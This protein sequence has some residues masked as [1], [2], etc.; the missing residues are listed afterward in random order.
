MTAR[1]TAGAGGAGRGSRRRRCW[2]V[3]LLLACWPAGASEPGVLADAGSPVVVKFAAAAD[4]A[5]QLEGRFTVA[6]SP[7]AAWGVLTDYDHLSDFVSSM[8]S[9]RVKVRDDGFV[10]VEQESAGKLLFFQ[11]TFHVL[12]KVREEPRK[13]IAF[14][15]VSG[16]SFKQYLGAWTL[17]ETNGGLEVIYRLTARGG[18]AAPA[19]MMRGASRKMV[20]DLLEQVRHRISIGAGR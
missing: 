4:G 12:L 9:S 20:G 15:D 2:P 5:V 3:L 1:G 19:F 17:Q 10:L 13:S 14:E 6:A 18:F 16:V 11:R 8:R 7:A